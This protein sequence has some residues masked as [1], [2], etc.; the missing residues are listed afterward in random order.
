VMMIE[1]GAKVGKENLVNF[2]YF[3]SPFLSFYF[4]SPL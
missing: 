2:T 1:M 3:Y 4:I